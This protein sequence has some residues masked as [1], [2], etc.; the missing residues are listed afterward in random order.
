MTATERL[1]KNAE[2]VALENSIYQNAADY[3][4]GLL[5]DK[6]MITSPDEDLNTGYRWAMI[7]T[8]RHFVNTPGVG[9]SLVAGIVRSYKQDLLGQL[10][11]AFT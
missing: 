4:T 10:R 5:D 1:Q 2:A 8:D 7:G 6:L 3:Y 11:H 9:K